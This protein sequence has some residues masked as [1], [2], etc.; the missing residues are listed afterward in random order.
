MKLMTSTSLHIVSLK[1][2]LLMG[3]VVAL[4]GV[5]SKAKPSFYLD[6]AYIGT[7]LFVDEDRDEQFI[8]TWWGGRYTKEGVFSIAGRS[9][10]NIP[11]LNIKVRGDNGWIVFMTITGR[12]L[13]RGKLIS[14]SRM[15]GQ[16]EDGSK[17]TATKQ[18]KGANAKI[19]ELVG[20]DVYFQFKSCKG[21]F[22][23]TKGLFCEETNGLGSKDRNHISWGFPSTFLSEEACENGKKLLLEE[24]CESE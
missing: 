1:V 17:F 19:W 12:E 22:N 8:L 24:I 14:E 3:L 9:L 10:G 21:F 20:S 7:W 23:R 6:P 5:E 4:T 15:E 16:F 2:A 18:D 11:Q 13:M